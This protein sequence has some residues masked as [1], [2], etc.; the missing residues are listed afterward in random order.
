IREDLVMPAVTPTGPEQNLFDETPEHCHQLRLESPILT[1]AELAQL[2][3]IGH[4][5]L[6]AVTLPMR[7]RVSDGGNGLRAAL[8][9][10]CAAAARAVADGATILVLS[11][12]DLDEEHAP[13]PRLLATRAVHHQLIRTGEG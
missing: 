3:Q 11:D 1:N 12:R 9:E 8:D 4:G 10:L 13:I 7:Y 5:Q 2:K 6:R